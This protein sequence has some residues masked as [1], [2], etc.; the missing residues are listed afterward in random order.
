ERLLE[1]SARA[2]GRVVGQVTMQH[3]Q[4]GDLD[5]YQWL[6]VEGAHETKHLEQIRRLKADPRFPRS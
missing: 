4:L 6:L 1:V 3:F 5:F 2:E